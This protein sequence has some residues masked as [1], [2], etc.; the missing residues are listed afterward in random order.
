MTCIIGVFDKE[1][2]CVFI[3]ADSL[4]SNGYSQALYKNKKV[5]KAKD[6]KNILMAISGDYK[7]QNILSIEE[8]LIEEVKS[9]V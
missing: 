5:F 2:D 4:G 6:N 9:E 8:N 1:K 3:G 7:L